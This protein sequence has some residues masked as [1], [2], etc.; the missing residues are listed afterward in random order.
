MYLGKYIL[1]SMYTYNIYKL[2]HLRDNIY[3]NM[4]YD[5]HII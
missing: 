5:N 3:N 2:Y 1:N 4:I